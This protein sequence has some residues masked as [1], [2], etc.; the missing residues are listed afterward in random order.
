MKK[1]IS[2]LL[3]AGALGSLMAADKPLDLGDLDLDKKD[4]QSNVGLQ[5]DLERR[6]TMLKWHQW[7]GIAALIPM[8]TDY[9]LGDD[10]GHNSDTRN[11][12]MGLGI[13]TTTLYASAALFAIFAPKPDGVKDTG[14]TKIHRWLSFIHLPLMIIVP[15]LGN[16]ARSQIDDGQRVSGVASLHGAAATTLLATYAISI[17]VLAFNF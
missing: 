15:L 1:I 4:I 9:F 6:S 3:I 8:A 7:L 17:T 11:W 10:A 12:H 2:A 16:A 13:A 5:A 14:S